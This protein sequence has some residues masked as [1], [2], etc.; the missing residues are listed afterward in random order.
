[1]KAKFWLEAGLAND[2]GGGKDSNSNNQVSGAIPTS[3]AG[4]QGLVFQRRSYVGLVGNFGEVKLGREYVGTY[5]G[6]L[7]VVDPFATNGPADYTQMALALGNA[8]KVAT[9]SNASNMITYITPNMGGFTGTAQYFYGENV[10]GAATSDDGT[11]YSVHGSYSAGPLLLALG[12][13]ETKYASSVAGVSTGNGKY[14]Q[15]AFAASYDFGVAKVVY[16]WTHEGVDALAGSVK[17]DTQLIGVVVPVGVFNIKADYVSATN[18][19]SGTDQKG[20]LY[21]LGADYS[22]SK[23]TKLYATYGGISNKDSGTAYGSSK[24]NSVGALKVGGKLDSYAFGIF[25]TF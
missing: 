2:F 20:E 12:Q 6:V 21:G 1:L 16:T 18:N 4:G 24:G 14:Q 9:V 17:N 7:A 5:L 25:H 10:S 8:L 3:A 22:L 19:A 15:Q 11:G 23:R 13:Q